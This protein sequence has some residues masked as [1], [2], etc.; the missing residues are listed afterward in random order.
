MAAGNLVD[1]QTLVVQPSN[2]RALCSSRIR[3]RNPFLPLLGIMFHEESPQSGTE[4]EITHGQKQQ[5]IVMARLPN[6]QLL[7]QAAGELL[8]NVHVGNGICFVI[9]ISTLQSLT[10]Q[11]I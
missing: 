6:G 11:K 5:L 10:F 7:E 3:S 9:T 4:I 1:N 2:Q 8:H